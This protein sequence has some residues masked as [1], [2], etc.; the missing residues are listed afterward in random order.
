VQVEQVEIIMDISFEVTFFLPSSLAVLKLP[1]C[2]QRFKD[3]ENIT[4]NTYFDPNDH[5][6]NIWI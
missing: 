5:V 6:S 1:T 3:V 2:L 4:T